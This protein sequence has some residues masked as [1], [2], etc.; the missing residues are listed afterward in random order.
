LTIC[1]AGRLG[2]EGSGLSGPAG[3]GENTPLHLS[4]ELLVVGT[5]DG[6]VWFVETAR[7]DTL[8]H[9]LQ[10][11]RNVSLKAIQVV[12]EH[13]VL[14]TLGDP[15]RTSAVKLWRL[16]PEGIS[17]THTVNFSEQI[18]KMG[19]LG[20]MLLLGHAFGSIR[21]VNLL[22]GR[23]IPVPQAGDHSQAVADMK[24][25][26]ALQHFLTCSPDGCIM[27]FDAKKRLEQALALESP[28]SCVNYLN[29]QGDIIAG[30]GDRLIMISSSLYI[31]HR[32]MRD[33]LAG[34]RDIL[35]PLLGEGEDDQVVSTESMVEARAE[36][37]AA[38]GDE[39]E[40]SG[41][42]SEE[43]QENDDARSCQD[44]ELTTDN[45]WAP[46]KPRDAD[47]PRVPKTNWQD[48][49]GQDI[50]ALYE[51]IQS[52]NLVP[53]LNLPGK[54]D[55]SKRRK[56]KKKKKGKSTVT[57]EDT[58]QRDLARRGDSSILVGLQELK[59]MASV[60]SAIGHLPSNS[61]RKRL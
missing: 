38:G 16:A 3:H 19:V 28:V 54:G 14:V 7:G 1:H 25:S 53:L 55:G 11:H 58:I 30:F 47:A 22:D 59:A 36:A 57:N 49:E 6:D 50:E 39:E 27:V 61:G 12:E 34:M 42:E 33:K 51:Q 45:L 40:E 17:H 8:L 56:K 35:S 18:T 43:S 37:R 4:G 15:K 5:E 46:R 9:R 20:E 41:S 60:T 2:L 21:M 44:V 13:R 24:P 48:N 31:N 23:H 26:V 29:E 52:G 32:R 10:S